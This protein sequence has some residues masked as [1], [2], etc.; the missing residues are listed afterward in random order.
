MWMIYLCSYTGDPITVKQVWLVRPDSSV[1]IKDSLLDRNSST[2]GTQSWEGRLYNQ[3]S[4]FVTQTKNIDCF[5]VIQ[6]M[7]TQL[8]TKIIKAPDNKYTITAKV[9]YPMCPPVC[10]FAFNYLIKKQ[11]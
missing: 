8:R 11:D 2:Y 7:T 1:T 6:P 5:G 10:M 9:D 3:D 4:L